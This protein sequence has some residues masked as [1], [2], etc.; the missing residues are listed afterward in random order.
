MIL[1]ADDIRKILPHR[2]PMLLV[3]RVT[4]LEPLKHAKGLKAVTFNEPYFQGHFPGKSVMPGVLVIEALAQLVH[5]TM[6]SDEQYH[7]MF[8]YYAGISRAK[9]FGT[10]TP[11]CILELEARLRGENGMFLCGVKASVSGE[12]VFTGDLTMMAV[13]PD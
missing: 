4:E 10:V 3:D 8:V 6:V 9:F 12:D 13:K 5:I 7:G 2:Y 1:S 11:G